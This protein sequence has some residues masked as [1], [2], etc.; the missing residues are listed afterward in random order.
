[1][2]DRLFS[3]VPLASLTLKNRIVF[4]AIG[5]HYANSDGTVSQRQI[6][7]YAKRAEG[8][9]ALV[10]VEFCA[11]DPL[12]KGSTRELGIWEDRF[13]E[14][15]SA[16]TSVVKSFGAKVAL[17][18]HHPGRMTDSRINGVAGVAPSAVPS[19]IMRE[20]P[21]ELSGGEIDAVIEGFV[22]G[23]R[24]AKEAGFDAVELHGASGYLIYQFFSPLANL[25]RDEWGGDTL[26]RT[27][28]TREIVRRTKALLGREYPVILR[29]AVTDYQK[30][31]LTL[32]ESKKIVPLLE[33]EGIDSISV[34]AGTFD[35][36]VPGLV[37]PMLMPRG[38]HVD[39]SAEIKK[40]GRAHV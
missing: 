1:M 19:A 12:Q 16:L 25:R 21:R 5:T 7:F 32:E 33:K 40:I 28:F 3:S 26:R 10:V 36:P 29:M 35:S 34:T 11:I 8:D 23:A 38:C 6:G 37:P 31:G 4:P 24:R 2:Y 18:L 39:F 20:A 22:Q 13:I 15:L 9:V 17:Q 30:G 14:G 27:R